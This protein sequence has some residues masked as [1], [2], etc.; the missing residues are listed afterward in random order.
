MRVTAGDPRGSLQVLDLGEGHGE[1]Y[2]GCKLTFM[3]N[4]SALTPRFVT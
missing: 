3:S 4:G 2:L 1:V